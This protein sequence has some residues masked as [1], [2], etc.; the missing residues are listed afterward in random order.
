VSIVLSSEQNILETRSVS[1]IKYNR[2]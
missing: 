2:G 1:V